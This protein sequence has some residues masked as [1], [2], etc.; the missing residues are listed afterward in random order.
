MNKVTS[1]DGTTIAYDR[2]GQGPALVL[3]DGAMCWRAQGPSG[4][5]ALPGQTHLVK[6]EALAPVLTAFFSGHDGTP[7]P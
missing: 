6:P 7:H 4:P 3:V 5:L 1:A 2:R